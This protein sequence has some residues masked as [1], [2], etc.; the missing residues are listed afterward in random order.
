M[1]LFLFHILS[2]DLWFYMT[3]AL[4][5]TKPLYWIHKKHHEKPHPIFSDAYHD[6]PLDSSIAAIGFLLPY[7]ILIFDPI[8]SVSALAVINVRGMLMHDP[9]GSFITGNHHLLHH[10]LANCNYGQY[11]IDYLMNTHYK[12]P[13]LIK[14]D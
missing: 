11:W 10:K 7:G 1:L 9:R 6:H 8:Q 3:H 13:K 4:L 2:Y 12:Q 14:S 5:H